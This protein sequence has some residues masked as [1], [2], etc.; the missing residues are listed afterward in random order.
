M[1]GV[2]HVVFE[3]VLSGKDPNAYG[4]GEA[5]SNNCTS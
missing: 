2:Q 3:I 5:R 4:D 1:W